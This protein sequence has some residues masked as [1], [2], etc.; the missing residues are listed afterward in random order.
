MQIHL[1][2]H[3]ATAVRPSANVM[4][5]AAMFGLGVDDER[6]LQIIPP[7]TLELH[8][9]QLVFVTGASGSGKSTLLQLV[10][11][12]A[13]SSGDLRVIRFDALPAPP[14]ASLVDCFGQTPLEQTLRWLSLAGLN[15]AFVMLRRPAELSD[16][17]RYRFRL[18]R[19]MA[20][21][22]AHPREE[23]LTVVLA[24]EFAATLDRLTAHVLARNV[25]KW[26]RHSPVCF[27]AATTHDDLLEPF[28]PDVLVEK[29]LGEGIDVVGAAETKA[30][31]KAATAGQ[32]EPQM[33]ADERG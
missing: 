15:D 5:V 6:H 33:N 8:P 9:H 10:D 11:E 32:P 25:R 18:A 16:G 4:Q 1:E 12:A 20:L 31:K 29:H 7:T 14:D 13:Q 24:D 17:Q 28:E 22:A 23:A 3:R 30:T 2:K 21:A 26:V 19:C 27:I